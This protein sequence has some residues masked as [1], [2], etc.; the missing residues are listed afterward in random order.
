MLFLSFCHFRQLSSCAS[1]VTTG[2]GYIRPK[3]PQCA[4]FSIS[5]YRRSLSPLFNVMDVCVCACEWIL[6]KG[7]FHLYKDDS[8]SSALFL[9]LILDWVSN[10]KS[11]I[12]LVLSSQH[13][14]CIIRRCSF[15]PLPSNVKLMGMF[16]MG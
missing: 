8:I 11:S 5:G 14:N 3:I 10:A 13:G 7:I 2:R 16:I 12:F 15:A 1:R 6:L 9:L 4:A